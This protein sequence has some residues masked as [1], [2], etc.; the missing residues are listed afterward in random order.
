MPRF[1]IIVPVFNVA[2]YLREALDSVWAQTF[3]DWECL[4]VDDGSTDGSGAILDEYAAK[5]PRFKVFRQANAGAGA[6]RNRGLEAAKGD[7]LLFLDGDDCFLPCLCRELHRLI[8]LHPAAEMIVFRHA[9]GQLPEATASSAETESVRCFDSERTI[10]REMAT[11]FFCDRAYRRS[12]GAGIRFPRTTMCEDTRYQ[13]AWCMP[14][15]SF[16]FVDAYWYVYRKREGSTTHSAMTPTKIL[17][18]LKV[19]DEID[20]ELRRS[21]KRVNGWIFR[22]ME[23]WNSVWAS[24][25]LEKLGSAEAEPV[26]RHLFGHYV[27]ARTDRVYT[28][29]FRLL[30][31]L[32]SLT[33]SPRLCLSYVACSRRIK[34]FLGLEHNK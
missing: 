31:W 27:R 30:A 22:H 5:D 8:E 33:R 23:W 7:W 17:D 21:G 4:C 6:A 2:P 18:A 29:W 9:N 10:P 12:V 1:S 3:P 24:V 20:G 19:W 15:R 14:V 28:R 25:Q 26:W 13:F 16:L 11:S 34:R 32:G